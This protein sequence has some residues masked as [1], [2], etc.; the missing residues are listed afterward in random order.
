MGAQSNAQAPTGSYSYNDPDR[1]RWDNETVLESLYD[2]SHASGRYAYSSLKGRRADGKKVFLRGR[3]ING[4][5]EVQLAHD[6]GETYKFSGIENYLKGVGDEP[7][8]LYRLPEL[9]EAMKSKPTDFICVCEGEK[10]VD[11]LTA[12]GFIATTNPNGALNWK[13]EFNST[14]AGREVAILADN[15]DKGRMRSVRLMEQL[16]QVCARVWTVDLPDLNEGGDVTD[17]LDAGRTNDEL[18][19]LIELTRGS[20]VRLTDFHAL[21]TTHNYIFGPT[22]ES[23][24][25]TSVNSRILPVPLFGSDG[26]PAKDSKGVELKV[27]ANKWLDEK[28]A[29]EQMTWAPGGPQIISD[30]LISDGGWIRRE[31]CNVFNL[32]RPPLSIGGDANEAQPWLDHVKKVYPDDAAH[33]VHWLAHRV[34]FPQEKINHALVLGGAQGIGKDTILEP[35]KSAVGPWNFTEVSPQAILGRFNGFSKSVI[36]RVSEA[37][38]LGDKDRFAFYD[39]MKTYTAAPPDVLRVDEKFMREYSVFNVCGVIITSNHKGDGFY[40]PEDDRRHYVAWSNLTKAELPEGYWQKLWGWYKDGG[41]GN[42]AAYLAEQDLSNFDEKSPPPK[43]AAFWDI[44]ASNSAPETAELSDALELIRWPDAVTLSDI[45]GVADLSF[46]E[47]LKD[48]RNSRKIPHK[49]EDCGYRP[50]RNPTAKAGRWKVE[51]KDVVVYTKRELS[52]CAAIS[53]A[54]KR[55]RGSADGLYQ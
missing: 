38:D 22:G 6:Q 34:Q 54:E 2:Y 19:R 51:G 11:S 20:G 29:V 10:D 52:T 46:A 30:H 7:D 55:A 37:R 27:A 53:A 48:R 24:P 23:W 42:V 15:D 26:R 13:P 45:V 35:V 47:W 1:P 49:M 8:L 9:V 39:H 32:Y 16:S 5:S 31:G 43:T 4:S 41:I 17:W 25:A 3:R 21:M 28:R 44:V 36:L 12:K 33:I 18:T 14:L 40:L 50:I